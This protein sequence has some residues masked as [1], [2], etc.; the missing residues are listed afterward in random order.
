M[1]TG[2]KSA[3]NATLSSIYIP[4]CI[5][6]PLSWTTISQPIQLSSNLRPSSS[7]VIRCPI[8][9]EGEQQEKNIHELPLPHF[10]PLCTHP[11]SCLFFCGSSENPHHHTEGQGQ[12]PPLYA[13]SNLPLPT[14]G[15]CTSNRPFSFYWIIPIRKQINYNFS[16]QKRGKILAPLHP[17]PGDFF[18]QTLN[19]HPFFTPMPGCQED[20]WHLVQSTTYWSCR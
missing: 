2:W 13:R 9:F 16:H 12:S 1:T 18:V 15:H 8:P 4:R 20:L 17:H 3:P 11:P 14:Q 7:M 10:P 5:R 6:S 19:S